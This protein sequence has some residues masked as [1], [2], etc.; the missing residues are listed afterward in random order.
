[1][2]HY[3]DP[4]WVEAIL[5]SAMPASSASTQESPERI[6][7]IWRSRQT[8]RRGSVLWHSGGRVKLSFNENDM[9]AFVVLPESTFLHCY[10]QVK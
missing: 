2:I 10:I 6:S 4:G 1:M 9:T 3:S 5:A 7:G 8:S